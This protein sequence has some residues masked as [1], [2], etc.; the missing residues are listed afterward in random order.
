MTQHQKTNTLLKKW[1][2]NLNTLPKMTCRWP[3]DTGKDAQHDYA[4]RYISQVP[5]AL[6]H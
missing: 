6:S 5:V 2:E 1:A 4:A 3:T